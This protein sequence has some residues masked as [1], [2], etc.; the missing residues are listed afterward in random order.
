LRAR[1]V[2]ADLGVNWGLIA[3]GAV[4]Y[5]LSAWI[6][7]LHSRH[8]SIA[9]MIGIPELSPTG[10]HRGKLLKDG[11]Y[12]VVRHPRYLS[13]GLAVI[14]VALFADYTGV[15]VL[16]FL[17]F[18]LGYPMLVFEERELVDRFGEEYRQ[19]QREVPRIL[20]RLHRTK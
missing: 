16:I 18:P 17:L 19:Y 8:L 15:Y 4:L 11:I 14:A 13:A 2:G 7:L 5:G 12:R 6:A 10:Q 3:I 20:P 1:L 9:T